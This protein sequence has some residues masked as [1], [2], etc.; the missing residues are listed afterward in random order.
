MNV[1]KESKFQAELKKKLRNMFPGC[2][3]LKMDPNEIQGIPDLLVLYGSKWAVLECKRGLTA[4]KRPNQEYYVDLL[5]DMSFSAFIYPENEE[6]I[7]NELQSA[8]R[9]SR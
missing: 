8:F 3:V 7:L 1:A 2:I 9:S 4:S 6:E 5:N